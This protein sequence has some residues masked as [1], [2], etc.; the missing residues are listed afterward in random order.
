[1]NNKYTTFSLN[2]SLFAF[3]VLTVQE[4]TKPMNETKMRHAPSFI[5]GLINLRGQIATVIELSKILDIKNENSSNMNIV[6]N[7]EGNL[8]AFAVDNVG[9]VLELDKQYFEETPKNIGTDVSKYMEGVYK[10]DKKIISI[11]NV[12]AILKDLE[13]LCNNNN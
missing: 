1:M 10:A 6:C 9:D 4:I 5:K 7:V 12:K 2:D 11:L 8:L 3:D 13:N